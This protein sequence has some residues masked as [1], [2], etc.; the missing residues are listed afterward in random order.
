MK[1]I[2]QIILNFIIF[3][4]YSLAMFILMIWY[5][6]LPKI[7][8]YHYTNG[9]YDIKETFNDPLIQGNAY[10]P[11]SLENKI[12]RK[13]IY[14]LIEEDS[15]IREYLRMDVPIYDNHKKIGTQTL[16]NLIIDKIE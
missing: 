3:I 5:G 16:I 10:H 7:S 1:Q 15:E 2:L 9:C 12:F 14:Q 6:K 11:E 13:K 8:P 4:W